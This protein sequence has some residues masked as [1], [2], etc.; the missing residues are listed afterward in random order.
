M[1]II[2]LN[3]VLDFDDNEVLRWVTANPAWA[4]G[5]EQKTGTLE[6]GKM[7]DVVIWDRHPFSVYARTTHVLIDGQT[8]FERS[9][10]PR[11]SDFE[12]GQPLD[13]SQ[14]RSER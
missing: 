3:A 13:I 6:A 1:A 11:L 5:V 9:K 14:Q 2:Q 12:L 4:I 8:I 7:A 10:L